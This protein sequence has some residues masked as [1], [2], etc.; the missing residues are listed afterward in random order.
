MRTI[1][2]LPGQWEEA[3]VRYDATKDAHHCPVC[4]SVGWLWRGWFT[5]DGPCGAVA[6][7]TD[8][9]VFVPV[10]TPQESSHALG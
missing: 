3:M 7:L 4:H 10:G 1:E 6:L 5:C 8:G 9:R 2:G